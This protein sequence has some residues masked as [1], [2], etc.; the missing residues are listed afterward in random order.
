MRLIDADKLG[1]TID[2]IRPFKDETW[3]SFYQKVLNCINK[4]PTVEPKK[5]EWG[6]NGHCTECGY[7]KPFE[8]TNYS[9]N[10]ITKY[11]ANYCHNCGADMRKLQANGKQVKNELNRVSKELNSEI[12]KSKSEIVP[13]YRDGWR[14]KDTHAEYWDNLG[15]VKEGGEK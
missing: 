9:S 6:R 4:A 8:Y 3:Y 5:G 11:Y 14:L 2:K 13:D 15:I 10:G 12:E 7:R 1:H